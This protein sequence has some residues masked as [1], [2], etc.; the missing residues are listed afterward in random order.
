MLSKEQK[1]IICEQI[2][3]IIE[4]Y[5]DGDM[6]ICTT[7]G[8]PHTKE[9]KE[10]GFCKC[11]TSRPA[12]LKD[13]FKQNGDGLLEWH[14]IKPTQNDDKQGVR[15]YSSLPVFIDTAEEKVVRVSG[16]EISSSPLSKK[17]CKAINKLF[18]KKKKHK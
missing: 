17:V 4:K 14:S 7:C 1:S 8:T 10:C 2:A 9:E 3:N 5:N 18:S 12:T 16:K 15:I 13:C 11:K 6:V